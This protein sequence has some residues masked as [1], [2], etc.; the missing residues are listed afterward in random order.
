MLLFERYRFRSDHFAINGKL[1]LSVH[2]IHI[3]CEMLIEHTA[4]AFDL[5]TCS[6]IES[7]ARLSSRVV[8]ECTRIFELLLSN[9]NNNSNKELYDVWNSKPHMGEIDNAWYRHLS[10][11]C[12]IVYVTQHLFV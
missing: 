8:C 10:T 5:E 2:R 7:R 9:N 3:K 6:R 12:T 4:N 11:E 1:Q